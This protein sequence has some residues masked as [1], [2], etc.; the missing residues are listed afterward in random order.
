MGLQL[1]DLQFD[2]PEELVASEPAEER[3]L[4]RD[5]VR[6]LVSTAR[7]THR[8][9]RFSALAEFLRPKDLLVVNQS[10]TLPAAL[11]A[12]G[13]PG[14][15]LLDLCTDYGDGLW[16]AEPR[17]STNEPGPL[18]LESGDR[19]EAGGLRGR[20][21]GSYPTIERLA[22]VRFDGDVRAA[23]ETD[24]RPIR[25][26]YV[27][28]PFP[29]D[30][31]Q[32]YF[33]AEPGSAEMPSAARP[34][35]ER[36]I[37]RLRANGIGLASITLHTGVSSLEVESDQCE[38]HCSDIECNPLYPEPFHVPP[39]TAR[40]VNRTRR[41]GGRI[42]A[43]GTTVVRA[44]ESAFEPSNERVRATGGF[45]QRFVTP[46]S[47]VFV[48]DGLLTGLHDPDT[49][50]LAMLYAIAGREMV[51]RGYEEAIDEGYLWHEFG[52]TNLLLP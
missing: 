1:A 37:T 41:R 43:V 24:G 17:K 21:V 16:L 35:T 13:P 33:A 29:L 45:T 22:F 32:T 39:A 34:F 52:D 12:T 10:A 4:D 47:D 18:P 23:L 27:D 50:H 42:V 19:I 40:A 6:L 38:L 48:V 26:G 3:G 49:T 2:R 9:A 11:D 31:Y 46:E 14:E 36:V 51:L 8:H 7:N 5:D 15:F 30:S 28:E 20:V 44:L 25:Y